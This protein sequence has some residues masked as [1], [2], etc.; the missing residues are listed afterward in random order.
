MISRLSPGWVA[1]LLVVAGAALRLLGNL[2]P[3]L[4][5]G[6]TPLV[7]L[8]FV[9]AVYLPRRWSWLVG[10]GAMALSELAFL[11]WNYQSEG[12]FFSPM[13]LVTCAF[14]VL[15]GLA[16]ISLSRRSSWALL[17]GGPIAGS[18]LFYLVTNTFSWWLSATTPS[19]YV[20]PQNFGGWIQ[21]N[22]TG[23]PGYPPTWLFLRNALAG[24]VIFTALLVAFFDP[25]RLALPS[26][27]KVSRRAL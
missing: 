13:L 25:E 4:L 9:G 19:L 24:D 17:F 2:N 26:A 14:Y 7:A 16:G 20:Y 21:A 12:R 15:M 5:P 3:A 10:L 11:P 1:L 27:A 18:I 22:T 23:W 8:S 6:F